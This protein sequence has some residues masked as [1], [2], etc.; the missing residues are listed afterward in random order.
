MTL[1]TEYRLKCDYCNN[2]SPTFEEVSY[3]PSGWV[4]DE[5]KPMVL[6]PGVMAAFAYSDPRHFCCDNHRQQWE[7]IHENT[8]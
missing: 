8:H 5:I 3:I 4:M 6:P 7:K 2:V 1:I